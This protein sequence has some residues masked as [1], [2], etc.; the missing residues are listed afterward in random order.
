M[1]VFEVESEKFPKTAA[2]LNEAT[3]DVAMS[4]VDEVFR[5]T[6]LEVVQISIE[7]VEETPECLKAAGH[8]VS[9]DRMLYAHIGTGKRRRRSVKVTVSL[10]D[11]SRGQMGHAEEEFPNDKTAAL[12]ARS[13]VDRVV[14][15]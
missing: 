11:L 4:G 9:A 3:Q 10:F 6:S 13:L 8:S 14:K 1:A 5:T 15:E 12:A 2:A 7:C